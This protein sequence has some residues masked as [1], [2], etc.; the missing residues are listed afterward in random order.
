MVLVVNRQVRAAAMYRHFASS[1]SAELRNVV[2]TLG[3]SS[4][5]K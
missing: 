4:F 1:A 2:E 5:V 3:I